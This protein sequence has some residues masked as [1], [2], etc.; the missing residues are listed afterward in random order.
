M[1]ARG[2]SLH[3]DFGGTIGAEFAAS[4]PYNLENAMR[5]SLYGLATILGLLFT[6]TGGLAADD[7]L[8]I[9]CFAPTQMIAS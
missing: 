1:L 6:A 5:A 7:K 9:I 4:R 3:H 8:R 2:Y